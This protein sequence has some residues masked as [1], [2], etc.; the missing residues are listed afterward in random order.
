MTTQAGDLLNL[1]QMPYGSDQLQQPSLGQLPIHGPA[2]RN[3]PDI[4]GA[5]QTNCD[6]SDARHAG[7]YTLCTYLLKMREYYRWEN[8]LSYFLPVPQDDLGIWLTAREQMW[9]NME[10]IP[11]ASVPLKDGPA[12]PFDID[13]INRDL[14]PRGY[15]YSAGYG[16]FNKPLFFLGRLLKQEQ[17]QG[18][19]I[20]LSSCEYAR[21]LAAPPA[22][23]RG[24]TIFARRESA[25]RFV[26]EKIDEWRWQK[27]DNAMRRALACYGFAE[28]ECTLDRITD[29]ALRVMILHEIGEGLVGESLG[30]AWH[31]LMIGLARSRAELIA[32]AVRD[33]LADCRC[34]LP[35]LLE[36]NDCASLHFYF[37]NL[38]GLRREL[39]LD[40]QSAYHHW[41]EDGDQR[42]LQGAVARGAEYWF[43]VA[44]SL[45]DTYKRDPERVRVSVE[46]L[47]IEPQTH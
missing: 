20:L 14:V 15:V 37:A 47:L 2:M 26:W 32:R 36:R 19:T 21:E 12:D 27:R 11:L 16:R 40:L 9:E 5:I 25:R 39:F 7:D 31:S 4:V 1:F 33:H 28:N 22:M 6:I 13:S 41:V 8:E 46:A 3:F 45:I 23:L 17:R 30:D 35:A 42:P 10:T 43:N 29:D 34:T 24:R 18:F 44:Q 38:D